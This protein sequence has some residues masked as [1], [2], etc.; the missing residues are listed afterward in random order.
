M[1]L[2][3]Y[4]LQRYLHDQQRGKQRDYLIRVHQ[5]RFTPTALNTA[6]T[7]QADVE[8]AEPFIWIA[9]SGY[10]FDN[11]TSLQV[12]PNALVTVRLGGPGGRSFSRDAVHWMNGIGEQTMPF[13]L[14]A[15]APINGGS[16]IHG[17]LQLLT[18]PLTLRLGILFIGVR[19]RRWRN[20]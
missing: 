15:P 6:F 9:T 12:T 10:A 3:S 20:V 14:G 2:C 19:L 5:L 7:D 11:A 13:Y 18:G 17:T 16:T 1:S 4:P 8:P